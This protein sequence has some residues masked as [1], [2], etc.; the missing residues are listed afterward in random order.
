MSDSNDLESF[1]WCLTGDDAWYCVTSFSIEDSVGGEVEV[2]DVLRQMT[3]SNNQRQWTLF[4]KL[5]PRK[6]NTKAIE[7]KASI[8]SYVVDFTN[9]QSSTK[10]VWFKDINDVWLKCDSPVKDKDK[11]YTHQTLQ[12][13]TAYNHTRK[14]SAFSPS[15]R[16]LANVT[17]TN[18]VD[19]MTSLLMSKS[20][21]N[22]TLR[23]N[24][25]PRDDFLE[26]PR[27]QVKLN[28]V[29]YFVHLDRSKEISE[30]GVF[31]VCDE[32]NVWYKLI[33]YSSEY[34]LIADT[35][36]Q[37]T[38]LS[39]ASYNFPADSPGQ[40][41]RHLGNCSIRDKFGNFQPLEQLESEL[42]DLSVRGVLIPPDN[43]IQPPFIIQV[44]LSKY[45]IDY[46]LH[47]DGPNRGLW[48]QDMSQVWY[49]LEYPY[50]PEYSEIAKVAL[51]KCNKFLAVYDALN[52]RGVCT[53]VGRSGKL[54]C[55]HTIG[56]VHSLASSSFDLNFVAKEKEFVLKHLFATIDF[57]KSAPFVK[58]I[59]NLRLSSKSKS[60]TSEHKSNVSNEETVHSSDDADGK[61]VTF[62][63]S[64]AFIR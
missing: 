50:D 33:S 62:L 12:S 7:I 35:V 21:S 52:T 24:L 48:V 16:A 14:S 64:F 55:K 26:C 9:C 31:W 54:Q 29:K 20:T 25:V 61:R 41:W 2:S 58:S 57:D 36:I 15:Y 4:G 10:D 22:Y 30:N 43:S 34:K 59:Q 63:R 13:L 60:G 38:F 17:V 51:V 40:V 42:V 23:G 47:H 11:I 46:G 28:A 37:N 6:S 3:Q 32:N 5:V 53:F 56:T 27:L 1:N 45:S 18:K 44:A 49:K 39:L 8:V 19:I